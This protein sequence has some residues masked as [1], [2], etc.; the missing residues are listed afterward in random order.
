MLFRSQRN[1]QNNFTRFSPYS[2]LAD[3]AVPDQKAV[4]D[5]RKKCNV[6]AQATDTIWKKEFRLLFRQWI[7]NDYKVQQLSSGI[8]ALAD[9]AKCSNQLHELA[10]AA[11]TILNTSSVSPAMIQEMQK[12]LQQAGIPVGYCELK[13]IEPLRNLFVYRHE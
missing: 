2:L 6:A 5:L 4:R 8:P 10:I 9:L 3:I 12:K 7:E 13:V 1:Q 11:L